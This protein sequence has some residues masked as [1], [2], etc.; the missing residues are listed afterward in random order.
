[1]EPSDY[2]YRI[3]KHYHRQTGYAAFLTVLKKR[4]QTSRPKRIGGLD[5]KLKCTIKAPTIK[6]VT[7]K[8]SNIKDT[9][10]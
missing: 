2:Q 7:V 1:M 5:L 9:M 8:H 6:H 4:L 3:I 10:T